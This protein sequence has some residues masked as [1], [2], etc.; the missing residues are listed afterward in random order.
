MSM[1]SAFLSATSLL[2]TASPYR[3]PAP[4]KPPWSQAQA[5]DPALLYF[6]RAQASADM[7]ICEEP[8][9]RR[10]TRS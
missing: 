10:A 8:V 3:L 7:N 4:R 1:V 5:S 9:S 6:R 2:S